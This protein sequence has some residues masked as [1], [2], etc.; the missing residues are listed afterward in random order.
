ME[1]NVEQRSDVLRQRK[2]K[3]VSDKEIYRL[4]TRREVARNT[5][6]VD[7]CLREDGGRFYHLLLSCSVRYS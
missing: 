5:K 1:E 2:I 4:V 7:T 3:E 6:M